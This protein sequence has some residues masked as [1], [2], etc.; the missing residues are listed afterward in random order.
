M[1]VKIVS[2]HTKENSEWIKLHKKSFI[3][4]AKAH[5]SYEYEFT[6]I[7]KEDNFFKFFKKEDAPFYYRYSLL[8]REI[9]KGESDIIIYVDSD[10]INMDTGP[11]LIDFNKDKSKNIWLT[12]SLNMFNTGFIGVRVDSDISKFLKKILNVAINEYSKYEK[13]YHV[14]R[15]ELV[16]F[17]D[18]A[19]FNNLWKTNY[20]NVMLQTRIVSAAMYNAKLQIEGYGFPYV[21]EIQYVRG[22]SKLLHLEAHTKDFVKDVI[23]GNNFLKRITK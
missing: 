14:V 17:H 16:S 4:L 21:P 11:L 12:P 20:D 19:I 10:V 18:E 23:K 5:S 22:V 15:G 6:E 8:I 2:C 9:I 7:S 13:E 1:K 3:E